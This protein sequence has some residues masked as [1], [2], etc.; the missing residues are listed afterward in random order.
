MEVW[1]IALLGVALAMDACAVAMTDGMTNPKMPFWRALLIGLCFGLF[2]C[3]MPLLGYY[4]TGIIADAFVETFEKISAWV[5][6]VLLAFLGGKMLFE[7][8]REWIAEKR[9]ET[10]P[11]SETQGACPCSIEN[12]RKKDCSG[13]SIGTL[14]LQSIATSID[15]L[16][17]GVT[18]QMAKLRGGLALGAWGASGLIGIITLALAFSAVYLG[19]LIGNRLAD[20]AGIFGGVVLL[21]IGIKILLEGLL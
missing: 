7:I 20:K 17:V 21:G 16:A 2:Q 19:R 10:T 11:K 15:A 14:F 5:S 18:L 13:L 6:F 12:K 8:I 4:I 9:G 1:E 3:L